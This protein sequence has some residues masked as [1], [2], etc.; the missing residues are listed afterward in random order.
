MI[1]KKELLRG[2]W[3]GILCRITPEGRQGDSVR[4]VRFSDAHVSLNP[5]NQGEFCRSSSLSACEG[6]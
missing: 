6:V 4:L 5:N 1:P 3:V 2:L